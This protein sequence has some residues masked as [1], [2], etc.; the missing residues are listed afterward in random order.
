M[1]VLLLVCAVLID[2][3]LATSPMDVCQTLAELIPQMSHRLASLQSHHSVDPAGV[4][5]YVM[6]AFQKGKSMIDF[7]KPHI[8]R[9]MN[10]NCD[11]GYARR[12]TARYAALF[13]ELGRV[14]TP[15]TTVSTYAQS[16]LIEWEGLMR[17][18]AGAEFD[19]RAKSP[20]WVAE[21]QLVREAH[22]E[23][24]DFSIPD[25]SEWAPRVKGSKLMPRSVKSEFARVLT[26]F[27]IPRDN[28][29]SEIE[30][31]GKNVTIDKVKAFLSRIIGETRDFSSAL[32][33]IVL[34]CDTSLTAASLAAAMS[35]RLKE[36]DRIGEQAKQLAL[37]SAMAFLPSGVDT[38]PAPTVTARTTGKPRNRALRRAAEASATTTTTTTMWLWADIVEDD[39]ASALVRTITPVM[40]ATTSPDTVPAVSSSTSKPTRDPPA[41]TSFTRKQLIN[42][43]TATR[44]TTTAPPVTTRTTTTT[45]TS[46]TTTWWTTSMP[47]PTKDPD[48][49]WV[50][51]TRKV[52]QPR[53]RNW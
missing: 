5:I 11:R 15:L 34:A 13:R 39:E 46:P 14:S 24:Y 6:L 9:M 35:M 19:I 16:S 23:L 25:L 20:E 26:L 22:S 53:R 10:G 43:W 12:V 45:T 7:D 49:E 18:S 29:V 30:E 41:R 52:T 31:V 17:E 44:R 37:V 50:V 36:W 33:S 47:T 51:A 42:P 48:G 27:A 2:G 38:K 40:T 21:V 8:E 28:L 4:D 32:K 3:R 1:R